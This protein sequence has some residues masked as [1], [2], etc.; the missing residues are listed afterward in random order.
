[1]TGLD[2]AIREA[3]DR[4]G[5]RDAAARELVYQSAR[6]ALE[7]G[8]ARHRD[9]DRETADEQRRRF[10]ELV[11]RIEAEKVAQDAPAAN[12]PAA[13]EP[14]AFPPHADDPDADDPVEPFAMEPIDP[15]DATFGSPTARMAVPDA[16]RPSGPPEPVARPA[17]PFDG[18]QAE[19][20]AERRPT[21]KEIRRNERKEAGRKRGERRRP[22]TAARVMSAI[23][24]LV[25]VIAFGALA[26]WF[27]NASGLLGTTVT[28]GGG[29]S[30]FRKFD[31]A[32][33]GAAPGLMTE[34]SFGKAWTPIFAPGKS[35]EVSPGPAAHVE[36]VTD[37]RGGALRLTSTTAGPDGDLRIR[38][39]ADLMD[40]MAGKTSVIALNVRAVG[41]RPTQIAIECAFSA[42][43]DCSRR[44]FDV[45]AEMT[46]VV[47][48]LGFSKGAP[49]R[50]AGYLLLNTDVEGKGRSIDLFAV[51]LR[52]G[53]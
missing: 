50:K 53:N 15:P 10:D 18:L 11:R 48:K 3:I 29:A 52:D 25:S 7:S 17:D 1:M 20:R 46:D 12:A 2:A 35:G 47:M 45:A 19:V 32:S 51:G 43:G 22:R 5:A 39:P 14:R 4:A 36:K 30:S 49:P 34:D 13:P 28:A 33:S 8:L 21:K 24:L 37:E 9:L 31:S 23:F 6:Q 40:R 44:R 27:V 41:G 26:L 16:G 38:V 42:L